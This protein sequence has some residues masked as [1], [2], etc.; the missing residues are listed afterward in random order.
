MMI[1]SDTIITDLMRSYLYRDVEPS[2]QSHFGKG[3][4]ITTHCI[5]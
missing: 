1:F 2:R 5:E 4:K 3:S